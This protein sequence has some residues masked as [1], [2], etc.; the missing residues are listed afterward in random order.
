M[1][2]LILLL[3][4]ILLFSGEFDAEYEIVQAQQRYFDKKQPPLMVCFAGVPGSGKTSTASNI[5]CRLEAILFSNDLIRRFVQPESKAKRAMKELFDR[6][7][8]ESPNGVWVLD[9]GIERRHKI[10]RDS[11]RE[12]SIPMIVV[13]L[14]TTR[15]TL[16]ARLKEREK[17]DYY[18]KYLDRWLG[19]FNLF[20]EE[21][22]WEL[23]FDT[24]KDTPNEIAFK[25][26][27]FARLHHLNLTVR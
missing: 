4:P 17:A 3:L 1:R 25:I 20:C 22:E 13:R 18:L 24:E 23:Q 8:N 27:R 5:S 15:D 12:R 26:E 9:C 7:M 6:L 14:D 2:Y 19:D 10:L 11:C 16:I 21:G